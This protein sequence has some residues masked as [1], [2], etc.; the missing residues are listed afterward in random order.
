MRKKYAA[1]VNYG[2]VKEYTYMCR[3]NF[4][5]H[6]SKVRQLNAWS[7]KATTEL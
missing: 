7:G 1:I 3:G 2:T 5:P 4:I 6:C